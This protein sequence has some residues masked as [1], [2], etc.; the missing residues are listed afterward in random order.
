MSIHLKKIL[1]DVIGYGSPVINRILSSIVTA[2]DSLNTVPETVFDWDFSQSALGVYTTTEM[3][4]EFNAYTALSVNDEMQ[5]VADPKSGGNHGNCLRSTH[6]EGDYGSQSGWRAHIGDHSTMYFAVDVYHPTGHEHVKQTKMCGVLS[7]NWFSN[8]GQPA[9]GTDRWSCRLHSEQSNGEI[10]FYVYHADMGGNYGDYIQ[11]DTEGSATYY[12]EDT[13][14]TIEWKIVLNTPGVLDGELKCW[15]DGVL[16]LDTN[17]TKWLEPG[18]EDLFIEQFIVQ[19]FYGGGDASFAP[20]SEQNIY[21]DNFVI[22]ETP[23]TH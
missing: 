3:I 23:I 15:V 21:F 2:V 12:L 1:T 20:S 17:E 14:Q 6:A 16:K 9:D 4:D 11:C 19:P 18:G 13:W 5:I 10:G 22:S 7:K 8:P